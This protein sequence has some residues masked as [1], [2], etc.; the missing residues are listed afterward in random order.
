MLTNSKGG[1]VGTVEGHR[2]AGLRLWKDFVVQV[3]HQTW[4]HKFKKI[5]K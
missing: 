5:N 2:K 4:Q 3:T 1:A